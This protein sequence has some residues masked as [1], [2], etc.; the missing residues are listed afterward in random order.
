MSRRV[1][2]KTIKTEKEVAFTELTCDEC[3]R[4][5]ETS[6]DE[7]FGWDAMTYGGKVYDICP[8]CAEALATIVQSMK[9]EKQE[10][11]Y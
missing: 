7:L 2:T 4:K 6:A 1:Y 10:N 8:S 9:I 11:L 3:G 5:E